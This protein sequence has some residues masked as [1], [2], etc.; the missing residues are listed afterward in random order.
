MSKTSSF[1]MEIERISNLTSYSLDEIWENLQEFGIEIAA[2]RRKT[3]ISD[4]YI[5]ETFIRSCFDPECFREIE[6]K[7]E[8]AVKAASLA[9][10]YG[11]TRD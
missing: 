9:E 10:L 8:N 5:C 3:G 4:V 7:H 1:D 6:R 11:A 2:L